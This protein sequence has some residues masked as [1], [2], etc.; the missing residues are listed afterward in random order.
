MYRPARGPPKQW[1]K[2][3]IFHAE[4]SSLA[5]NIF[6]GL[7]A[8]K[9]R[10][11]KGPTYEQPW[12]QFSLYSPHIQVVPGQ[13]GGGSFRFETLIAYRAEQK[14]VPIGDRQASCASQQQ[15]LD[16]SIWCHVFWILNLFSCHLISSHRSISWKLRIASHCHR[17]LCHPIS[18]QLTSG[19]RSFFHIISSHLIFSLPC[20]ALLSWSTALFSSHVTWAFLVSSHLISA[21][22][23]FSQLF[24][25]LLSFPQLISAHLM[26]S[27][28]FSPL[29]TSSK[30]FSH[31]LSWSQLLPARVTSSQLFS[32][33]SQIISALLFSGPKPA[34]NKDLG[35]KASDPYALRFHREDFDTENL[36]TQ[37]AFA[38]RSLYTEKFLHTASCYTQKLL[39]REAFTQLWHTQQ[40]STQR[41]PYTEKLLHREA[42]THN[43]LVHREPLHTASPYTEKILHREAFTQSKLLHRE[44]CTQK[45]FYTEKLYTEKLLHKQA[46]T[47]RSVYTEEFYTE[48]LLHTAS[49]H[50]GKHL[51]REAFTHRSFYTHRNLHCRGPET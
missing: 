16:L 28:L 2:W 29:L 44:A 7:G 13:A 40:A 11:R 17:N 8:P 45:S 31:L 34:P 1:E 15:A 5:A 33:D 35:A 46:F 32:A 43:K 51:H 6:C 38:Q 18:S 14:A 42:F 19:F 9:K 12:I 36:Y 37:Q 30:L 10:S 48:E 47:H 50:T 39:H 27:H 21:F 20:S 26:S 41:S 49:F 23:R 25:T 24:S 3:P 22:L 4:L